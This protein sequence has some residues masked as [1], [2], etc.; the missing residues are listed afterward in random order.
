[1]SKLDDLAREHF[2][3]FAMWEEAANARQEARREGFC[4]GFRAAV[5]LL[6][7]KNLSMEGSYPAGY[8]ANWLLEQV[9]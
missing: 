7:E 1:M 9:K 4:S 2:P 6:D 5:K 8:W 3:L